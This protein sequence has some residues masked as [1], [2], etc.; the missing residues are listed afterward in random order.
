MQI[1]YLTSSPDCCSDREYL[2]DRRKRLFCTR[3]RHQCLESSSLKILCVCKGRLTAD[4]VQSRCSSNN[5]TCR[6]FC[7]A[8]RQDRHQLVLSCCT[9]PIY[10]EV[11]ELPIDSNSTSYAARFVH[12]V[13][14]KHCILGCDLCYGGH[15]IASLYHRC[16]TQHGETQ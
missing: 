6:R 8:H 2:Q 3:Y 11:H 4:R 14:H 13:L 15:R 12:L 7:S 10:V 1:E 5:D 16:S 9:V